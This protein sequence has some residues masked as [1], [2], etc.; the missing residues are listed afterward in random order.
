LNDVSLLELSEP[1]EI[2][3]YVKVACLPD[4]NSTSFPDIE[5]DCYAS[6]WV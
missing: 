6:G 2:N 5:E 1:V 3:R 4:R